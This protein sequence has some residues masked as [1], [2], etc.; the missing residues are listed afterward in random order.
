M[1]FRSMLFR[2]TSPTYQNFEAGRL[3]RFVSLEHTRK[4][5]LT[6]WGFS[7]LWMHLWCG[8][9]RNNHGGSSFVPTPSREQR[10]ARSR[11]AC[12]DESPGV[13]GPRKGFG[14]LVFSTV[15]QV[16]LL[17]CMFFVCK[18]LIRHVFARNC[19]L[20]FCEWTSSFLPDEFF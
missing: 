19:F 16:F 1:Y 2:I 9:R 10:T 11:H 18:V 6:I 15:Y 3:Q 14:G 8:Q 7:A 4:C 17:R 12:K 20:F 13:H 5:S